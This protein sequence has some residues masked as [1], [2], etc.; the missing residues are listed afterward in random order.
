MKQFP[1]FLREYE[2]TLQKYKLRSARI[3]AE[4]LKSGETTNIKSSKFLGAPYLPIGTDYPKDKDG[5]PLILWA[6]LNFSEIPHLDDYPKNG[7]MQFFVSADGWYDCEEIKVLFHL[8]EDLY[9][10]CPIWCEHRLQFK[11]AEEYGGTE[12]FRCNC[13]FNGKSPWDLYDTLESAQKEAFDDLFYGTGHKI[14]GYSYF[15]QTDPRDYGQEHKNDVSLLQIDS[16]DKIMFGDTGTAHFFINKDDLK[17]RN[18]DKTWMYW[19]CC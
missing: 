12:D 16:D 15:A 10:D 7:I 11:E 19:D 9:E 18:F 8:T 1:D 17:N 13:M 2:P 4:P 5:K 14:G 6:Q 3:L